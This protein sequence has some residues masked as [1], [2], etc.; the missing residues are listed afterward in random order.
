MDPVL[1]VCLQEALSWV[2][3]KK[4]LLKHFLD[5]KKRTVHKYVFKTVVAVS[6]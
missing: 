5:T 3:D 4:Y 6:V 2:M 1:F